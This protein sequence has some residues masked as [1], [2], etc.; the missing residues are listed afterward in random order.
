MNRVIRRILQFVRGSFSLMLVSLVFAHAASGNPCV[1][2]G[3]PGCPTGYCTDGRYDACLSGADQ[4]LLAPPRVGHAVSIAP[5]PDSDSPQ[6]GKLR[7]Q[8]FTSVGREFTSYVSTRPK[9]AWHLRLDLELT[10]APLY[11]LLRQL[12]L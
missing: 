5:Q 2:C 11:L 3:S 10:S 8:P 4:S 6:V 9:L 12:R 1:N 7:D